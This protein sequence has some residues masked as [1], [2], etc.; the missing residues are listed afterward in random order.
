MGGMGRKKLFALAKGFR[1]RSKN[2]VKSARQRVE[3]ALQYAYRDRRNKKRDMRSL[4]I[5]RVS[6]ASRLHGVQYSQLMHG[7]S[8]ENVAL[9]RKVL[10]ELAACEPYSFRT[11]VDIARAS[12]AAQ[13]RALAQS[14]SASS[15]SSS[16]SSRHAEALSSQLKRSLHL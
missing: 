4:W 9:N 14:S 1:G 15:S 16:R 6:A 7:L 13:A 12:L 11:V 3:K 10:S 2:C 8:R 5:Q